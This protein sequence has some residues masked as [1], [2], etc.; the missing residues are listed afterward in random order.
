MY[1]WSQQMLVI[2]SQTVCMKLLTIFRFILIDEIV[3]LYEHHNMTRTFHR[4]LRCILLKCEYKRAQHI[5][6]R[7]WQCCLMLLWC[8]RAQIFYRNKHRYA[9]H[10]TW[11][12]LN[13]IFPSHSFVEIL[14]YFSIVWFCVW[15]H[16]L[17]FASLKIQKSVEITAFT[18]LI[19][20]HRCATSPYNRIQNKLSAHRYMFYAEQHE[21]FSTMIFE[22]ATPNSHLNNMANVCSSNFRHTH[23]H[24]RTRS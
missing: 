4:H 1:F 23:T 12:K 19:C 20:A 9:E 3:W 21:R 6:N 7:C 24:T 16:V 8:S 22:P 14:W 5:K 17:R 18:M 11:A 15:L 10:F 13:A 2:H